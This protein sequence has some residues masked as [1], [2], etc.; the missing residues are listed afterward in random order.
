[1]RGPRPA[2]PEFSIGS[3]N[4]TEHDPTSASIEDLIQQMAPDELQ[5]LLEDLGFNRSPE[6][7]LGIQRLVAELGTLDA[8]IVA[9]HDSQVS[10]RAA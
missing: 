2:S 5:E 6:M 4:M 7:A 1:M 10:R 8:A 3:P 9:L